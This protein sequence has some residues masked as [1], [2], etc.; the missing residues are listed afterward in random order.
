MEMVAERAEMPGMTRRA[1][2]QEAG[3][4]SIRSGKIIGPFGRLGTLGGDDRKGR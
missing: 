3:V 2:D 1:V 4:G